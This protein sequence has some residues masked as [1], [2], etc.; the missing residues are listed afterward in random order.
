MSIR[1]DPFVVM[2][3]KDYMDEHKRLGEVLEGAK[4]AAATAE[5]KKQEKEVARVMS[6]PKS[7]METVERPA[8]MKQ[9]QEGAALMHLEY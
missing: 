2:D 7:K 5:R 6:M 3:R 9:Q 4:T 8:K 1:A